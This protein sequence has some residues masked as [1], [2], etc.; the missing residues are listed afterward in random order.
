MKLANHTFTYI[1]LILF[2][3]LLL[4]LILVLICLSIFRSYKNYKTIKIIFKLLGYKCDR[5][6]DVMLYYISHLIGDGRFIIYDLF[7]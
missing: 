3:G 6:K 7:N 5:I 4:S 2:V 1:I